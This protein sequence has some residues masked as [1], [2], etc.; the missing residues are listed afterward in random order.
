MKIFKYSLIFLVATAILV[1][2]VAYSRWGEPTDPFRHFHGKTISIEKTG[3]QG[4]GPDGQPEDVLK[5]QVTWTGLSSKFAYMLRWKSLDGTELDLPQRIEKNDKS[6]HGRY[7]VTYTIYEI[8]S[9]LR[10][11]YFV[12]SYDKPEGVRYVMPPRYVEPYDY[13]SAWRYFVLTADDEYHLVC[14]GKMHRGGGAFN[15][16]VAVGENMSTGTNG[17]SA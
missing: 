5:V 17:T 8:P 14:V 15:A 12:L 7:A 2:N 11:T 10:K 16:V 3:D 6:H 13:A 4:F 1:P 9:K